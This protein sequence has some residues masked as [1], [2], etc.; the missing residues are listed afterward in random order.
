MR[1]DN[2]LSQNNYKIFIKKVSDNEVL[3]DFF[4][5]RLTRDVFFSQACIAADFL[6]CHLVFIISTL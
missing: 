4:I 6:C 3:L 2:Y 1:N 5:V